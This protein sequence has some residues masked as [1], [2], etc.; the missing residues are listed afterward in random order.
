MRAA[1][2]WA[3]RGRSAMLVRVSGRR[4]DG[5]DGRTEWHLT[6]TD[7]RGPEIPCLPAVLLT[8][9]LL[10]GRVGGGAGA[11][12]CTGLL[13]L[14]EFREEFAERGITWLVEDYAA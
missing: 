10:D 8:R 7:N 5:R 3:G 2:E 14:D 9:K 1:H 6:A 12:A 13:Q 4:R 11:S